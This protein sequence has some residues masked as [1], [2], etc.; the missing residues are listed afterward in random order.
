MSKWVEGRV[1]ARHS[2]NQDHFTLFFEAD[3]PGFQ[4]GQFGRV[5]LPVDGELHGKPY[6]YVNAPDDRP[7]EILFN[8]VP[9]GALS[10]RLAALG[11]GDPIWAMPRAG[12]LLTLDLIPPTQRL[13]MIATGTGVGPFLS[14]LR[15]PG[16][17]PRCDQF[18][19][20]HGVRYER[21]LCY[22]EKIEQIHAL[23]PT[24]FSYL[25]MLTRDPVPEGNDRMLAG[26]IPAAIADGSLEALLGMQFD[27]ESDHVML[28]GNA[29]MIADTQ[30]LLEQRGMRRHRQR[31][32]GQI[33]TEKYH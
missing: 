23:S 22:R 13:W 18:I 17:W 1:V 25:P 12:G 20:V 31:E 10:G 16:S 32:P 15:D 21:D 30:T 5:A 26:R 7:L 14:I 27:P 8:I 9:G 24:Q 29:G 28:C 11:P 33:S 6:S 2:W 4:A 3:V 19:L